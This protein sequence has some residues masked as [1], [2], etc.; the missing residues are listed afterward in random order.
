VDIQFN[1]AAAIKPGDI[2]AK[3][4]LL[5]LTHFTNWEADIDGCWETTLTGFTVCLSDL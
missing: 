2:V 4:V 5:F 1:R 3:R